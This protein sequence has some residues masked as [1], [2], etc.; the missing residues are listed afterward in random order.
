MSDQHTKHD[1]TAKSEWLIPIYCLMG[2]TLSVS[3][4]GIVAIFMFKP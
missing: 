2:V 3:A 4:V 1:I